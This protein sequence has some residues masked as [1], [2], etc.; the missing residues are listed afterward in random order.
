[1]ADDDFYERNK[2]W[3]QPAP[4]GG[5][6]TKLSPKDETRFQNWVKLNR[7]PFDPSPNADYDMR[8]FFQALQAG[9]KRAATAVNANDNQ[10]HFPDYWKTPYHQ[11]FSAESKWATKGA[12]TW[13]EQDQLVTPDGAVVFDERAQNRK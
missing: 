7:V 11:S 3:A 9:D 10:M 1:M 13:N 6:L 4:A 2:Q 8:G 5:Y 12:P